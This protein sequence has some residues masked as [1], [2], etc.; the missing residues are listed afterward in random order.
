MIR[1]ICRDTFILSR[2]SSPANINDLDIAGDL[3][4][5][6]KYHSDKCVGMACNMIGINK[7]IIAYYDENEKDYRLMF[8]PNIVDQKDEY[9]TSEGC[10]SLPGERETKRYRK[11][12]VEYDN[13]KFERKRKTYNGLTAQIIQHEIDMCNGILI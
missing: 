7:R 9:Q 3:L 4:D 5:T 2:M 10:L 12:V 11:I 6:L 8:N 1:E 13:N